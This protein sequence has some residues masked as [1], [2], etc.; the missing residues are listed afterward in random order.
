MLADGS[1]LTGG[2]ACAT[3]FR[4]LRSE[5]ATPMA[6]I[7]TNRP[8]ASRRR[9][10]HT[11]R[12]PIGDCRLAIDELAIADCRLTDW[13]VWIGIRHQSG[14]ESSIRQ[15]AI[16]NRQFVNRQLPICNVSILGRLAS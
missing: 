3:R 1:C 8:I 10:S 11:F 12:F 14:I 5:I 16:P 2:G 15:S 4:P 7:T 6:K 9:L 13:G